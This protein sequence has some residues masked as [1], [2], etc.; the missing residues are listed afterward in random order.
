MKRL[1]QVL[2][3]VLLSMG[4]ASTV[5]AQVAVDC[6]TAA[7]TLPGDP[8]TDITV[9]CPAGCTSGAVWGTSPYSDDSAI[10]VAAIHAGALT[11]AGG[12]TTIAI[13]PGQEAYPSGSANGVSTSSWGAWHRGYVFQSAAVA[14]TCGQNAQTLGGETG[15]TYLVTCPASCSFGTVWGTGTYSDDSDVC[16]AAVHAGVISSAGGSVVVTIAAGQSSYPASAANGITT[17]EWGT[18]GRSFT[19]ARP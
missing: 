2:V 3:A 12:V 15:R 1:N 9:T 19:V 16:A 6:G 11:A 7:N 17:A 8:G 14:M 4:V 10:C 18:W 5:Q 13:V